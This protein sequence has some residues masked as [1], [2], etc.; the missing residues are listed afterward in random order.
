[1]ARQASQNYGADFNF[2][3]SLYYAFSDA[4]LRLTPSRN[5]TTCK[6]QYDDFH[7]VAILRLASRNYDFREVAISRLASRNYDFHEVA[8]LR[9]ASRNYDF[10]EVAILRL[11][12]CNMTTSTKSQYYDLQAVI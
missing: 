1:M 7:E 3:K 4:I 12:S 10:H 9:L 8:I 11:V 2:R 6:L 5:I